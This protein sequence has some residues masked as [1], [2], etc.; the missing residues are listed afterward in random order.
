[1]RIGFIV[2]IL[3]L[4][5]GCYTAGHAG[6][7]TDSKGLETACAGGCAEFRSDG[8]R[9]AKFQKGT[10]ESCSAYFKEICA[11]SPKQCSNK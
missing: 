9:C 8:T 10:S 6:R 7:T 4:L 3:V 5:S 11:A 2:G 1:M